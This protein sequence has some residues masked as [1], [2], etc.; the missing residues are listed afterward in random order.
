MH[1]SALTFIGLLSVSLSFSEQYTPP[2]P[3][4]SVIGSHVAVGG[5]HE[6]PIAGNGTGAIV[7]CWF[8][9]KWPEGIGSMTQ[10]S[11]PIF[12]LPSSLSSPP[13]SLNARSHSSNA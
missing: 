2:P 12:L 7:S 10:I 3:S 13:S 11:S 4:S 6:A 8:S 9:W 1:H 5:Y